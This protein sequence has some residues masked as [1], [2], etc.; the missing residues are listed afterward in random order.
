MTKNY[1]DEEL[2]MT[3]SDLILKQKK[4][5]MSQHNQPYP[6]QKYA[7]IRNY[8][9]FCFLP[10]TSKTVYAETNKIIIV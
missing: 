10:Y 9:F 7:N 3:K 6:P 1:T 2:N 4:I 8:T 5:N